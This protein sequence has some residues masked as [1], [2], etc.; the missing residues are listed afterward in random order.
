MGKEYV[1]IYFDWLE[2]TQDLTAEEKGNLIDAVVSYASGLE[3]DHLLT[4]C[5]RIAF[6]FFKGQVDRN[7]AISDARSKA[8][9]NKGKQDAASDDEPEQTTTNDNKTQQT[10]TNDN[11]QQ[12]TPTKLPKEK[13]KEKEKEKQKE[14][15]QAFA[16]FWKAYP[17]KVNKPG[18][19]RAFDKLPVDDGLLSVMLSAIDKQKASAQWQENGGQYI[20]HPAT[21]LNG[22]RWEDEIQRI[23]PNNPV[24]N[25]TQRSYAG[26]QEKALARMMQDTWGD[27]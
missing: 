12:Q 7:A 24:G 27:E 17:R 9:I 19:K 13:E 11:K 25:Y 18:A 10:I 14:K 4:G 6:R 2:V 20:P 22:R 3:Y 16:R 23:A 8:R 5:A 1:P 21:W 26:E 15:E